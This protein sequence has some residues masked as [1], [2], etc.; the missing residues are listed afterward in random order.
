M[1][2]PLT[3][4]VVVA[5][6]FGACVLGPQLA[7]AQIFPQ[8]QPSA[9]PVQPR[10]QPRPP[11]QYAQPPVAPRQFV[12]PAPT[13]NP[14]PVQA[15]QERRDYRDRRDYRE[16]RDYRDRTPQYYS[17]PVPVPTP[18]YYTPAPDYADEPYYNNDYTPAYREPRS[19]VTANYCETDVGT[20]DVPGVMFTGRSCKC[21]FDGYGTVR[22]VSIQ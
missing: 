10:F 2:R 14:P 12:R 7:M 6:C 20:C 19:R 21:W 11:V 8:T 9:P 18:Y 16:R 4:F 5:G 15:Y 1:R 17:V 22:G 3:A 13:Y